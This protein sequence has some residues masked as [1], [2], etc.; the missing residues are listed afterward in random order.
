MKSFVARMG[1]LLIDGAKRWNPVVIPILLVA[2]VTLVA[3]GALGVLTDRDES[4]SS[5][6]NVL[7]IL[8]TLEED[9]AGKVE[10][11]QTAFDFVTSE[12]ERFDVANAERTA[13]IL[14]ELDHI[15]R[16]LREA[17]R[18]QARRAGQ[19]EPPPFVPDRS[20]GPIV[21]EPR[22]DRQPDRRHNGDPKPP[23]P[24]PPRPEPPEDCIVRLLV[25][26]G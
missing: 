1:D 25:C 13:A 17:E 21:T 22:E 20:P 7:R 23:P 16:E 5:R 19:P 15:R 9:E 11:L 24:R 10:R 2:L 4:R 3:V 14:H 26:I 8:H 6:A 12:L 18:T